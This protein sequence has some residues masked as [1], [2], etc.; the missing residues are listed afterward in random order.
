[1]QLHVVTNCSRAPSGFLTA[2]CLHAQPLLNSLIVFALSFPLLLGLPLVFT[3]QPASHLIS[4][5]IPTFPNRE[6]LQSGL[7]F[8][9]KWITGW[10]S[11]SASCTKTCLASGPRDDEQCSLNTLV[12][13]LCQLWHTSGVSGTLPAKSI[14]VRFDPF[15]C[16]NRLLTNHRLTIMRIFENSGQR[17]CI[18]KLFCEDISLHVLIYLGQYFHQRTFVSA[19]QQHGRHNTEG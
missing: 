3:R 1:M 11:F 18:K 12:F 2:I 19:G 10:W 17:V 8:P 7:C 13:K 9:V 16:Q 6:F 4:R 15:Q 5:T 14:P